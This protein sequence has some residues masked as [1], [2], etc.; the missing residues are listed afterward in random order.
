MELVSK[1]RKR[2]A[3]GDPIR[4]G[5]VGCGQ[6]GSGLAHTINNVMGMRVAAIAD[7]DPGRGIGTYR[8]MGH[9]ADD[10]VVTE[11]LGQAEDAIRAGRP[12]GHAD[13][14]GHAGHST[15]WR[16]SSRSPACPDVGARVAYEAIMAR[17]PIIMMNVETDITIG[18]YLDRLA[19]RSGAVYTVASAT[20]R[21]SARCSA[22][23]P[24]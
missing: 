23:R 3:D 21:A 10:I 7:I 8:D 11:D 24:C 13:G 15:A 12:R 20:S 14:P 17:K 6:M 19:R 9:A 4:V 1:L 16:R 18:L 5:I 2:A 22:S